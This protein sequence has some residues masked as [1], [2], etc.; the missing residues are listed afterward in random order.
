MPELPDDVD[1]ARARW[2]R[3]KSS[4]ADSISEMEM[5]CEMDD[6]RASVGVGTAA[7]CDP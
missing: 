3:G 1:G 2:H 7:A 6:A 4:I 5:R